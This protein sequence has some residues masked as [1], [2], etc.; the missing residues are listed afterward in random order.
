MARL[1]AVTALRAGRD[2]AD[3]QTSLAPPGEA[4]PAE[5]EERPLSERA[6]LTHIPVEPASYKRRAERA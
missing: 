5:R 6:A 4:S 3:A 1:R 2:A